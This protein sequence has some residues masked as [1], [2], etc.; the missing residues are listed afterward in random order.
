MFKNLRNRFLLLNM[1]VTSLVMLVAFGVVYITTYRNI[2]AEN[3]R[4]LNSIVPIPMSRPDNLPEISNDD[5]QEEK[6][7]I[8]SRVPNINSSSS[9]LVRTDMNGNVVKIDS[10]IELPNQIYY[11]ATD[12]AWNNKNKSTVSLAGRLWMYSVTRNPENITTM[13]SDGTSRQEVYYRVAFLDITD[14]HKTLNDL[15]ATFAVISVILIVV[16]YFISRF[17]SNQAI[18][19][20][21]EVWEKQRQF[22]ADASHELKTP[23]SI[24]TA[25]Y[26]ALLINQD[27]TIRSQKEWLDY[28]KIGMEKMARLINNLLSLAK[29]ENVSINVGKARFNMSETIFE[30]MASFE[31]MLAE[32]K[33][34][35]SHSIEQNIVINSDIDMVRQLFSILYENAIKYT[36]ANGSIDVALVKSKKSVICSIKNSGKGIAPQDISK[37]F[38]RFYR[39]DPSRTGENEGFGLGLSIAKTIVNRLGGDITVESKE[40]SWTMF[41]FTLTDIV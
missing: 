41:T 21:A 27:E 5:A 12:Y 28:M 3:Q 11:E 16:I 20:I 40:N 1:I 24:I 8:L 31:A 36:N 14:T 26:D 19:P 4:K 13:S 6:G 38:D 33:I 22:I 15:L 34:A 10:F 37:I 17:Y 25:N 39:G 29:V 35:L 2:Y 18:K 23:L 7:I 32:K 9:F 30:V